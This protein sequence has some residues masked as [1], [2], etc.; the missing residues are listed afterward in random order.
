MLS[1]LRI[2]ESAAMALHAIQVLAHN[3]DRLVSTQE[4]AD[5]YDVS[6]HHLAKV[7]Q[8]LVHAGLIRSVRGPKGGF[9]LARPADR[10]RLIEVFEAIEGPLAPCR[11]LLG[12][13]VCAR[14]S[15]ILGNMADRVNQIVLDVFTRTTVAEL[16]Q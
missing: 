3:P 15:C 4:I 13:P 11:C 7:Q 16:A 14:R 6:E 5:T 9:Q 2:S 12:R 10:I 1:L 8:R